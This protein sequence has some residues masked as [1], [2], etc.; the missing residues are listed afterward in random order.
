MS[1]SAPTFFFYTNTLFNTAF[2]MGKRKIG[3]LEKVEADLYGPLSS[4]A[5]VAALIISQT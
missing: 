5:I 2:N 4:I 3:A 1:F